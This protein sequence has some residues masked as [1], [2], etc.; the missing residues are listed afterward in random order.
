MARATNRL[1]ELRGGIVI[2]DGATMAYELPLPLGG[3]MTRGT[4]LQAAQWED[5]LRA[6]LVARGY[7]HHE[8]L[9]TLFFL[10]ADFLPAARLT[11]R[12]VWDV[13]RGRVLLPARRRRAR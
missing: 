11:P 5:E 13:K 6:A 2:A 3:V 8:P 10:S 4:L 1:L 12:G 7:P 9:F